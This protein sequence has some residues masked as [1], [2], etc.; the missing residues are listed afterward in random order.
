MRVQDLVDEISSE[1][2][3]HC[4]YD[5]TTFEHSGFRFQVRTAYVSVALAAV[6]ALFGHA[7]CSLLA[8]KV[9]QLLL[10]WLW[11]PRDESSAMFAAA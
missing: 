3:E 9:T 1:K 7:L 5:N 8:L 2:Y 11:R 4:W 10:N 6:L